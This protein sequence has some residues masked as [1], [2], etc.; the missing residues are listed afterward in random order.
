MKNEGI[1]VYDPARLTTTATT[2]TQ[3]YI[4]AE[5]LSNAGEVLVPLKVN[6][7]AQQMV[8]NRDKV[9]AITKN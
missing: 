8:T 5:Y 3:S 4:H 2:S 6:N 1:P 7:P 9:E